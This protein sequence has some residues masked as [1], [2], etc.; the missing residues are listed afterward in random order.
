MTGPEQ[1]EHTP[2][3]TFVLIDTSTN[4]HTHIGHC[5]SFL[6]RFQKVDVGSSY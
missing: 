2:D 1:S 6:T 3:E 4:D 5:I